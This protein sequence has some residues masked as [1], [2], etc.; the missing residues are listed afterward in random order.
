MKYLVME[1]HP[2]YAVVLDEEGRFLKAANLRYQVGDT[3]QNIVELRK[4]KGKVHLFVES[5]YP[6]WQLRPPACAWCSSAITSPT[7]QPTARCAS[8]SIRMWR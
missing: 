1:V 5:L 6:D 8:R 4:P 3:V 2:A 7:T